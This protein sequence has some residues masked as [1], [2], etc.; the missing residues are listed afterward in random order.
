MK[1]VLK[2]AFV[3][4]LCSLSANAQTY[5]FDHLTN[6]KSTFDG[7]ASNT[8]A[9]HNSNDDSFI[10]FVY[11]DSENEI[12]AHLTDNRNHK[13]HK[14]KVAGNDADSTILLKFT[15]LSSRPYNRDPSRFADYGYRFVKTDSSDSDNVRFRVEIFANK[16]KKKPITHF[17]L[18]A[19]KSYENNFHFFR[20]VI[21]PFEFESRFNIDGY[22]ITQ[23]NW[24]NFTNRVQN[25][26]LTELK[27]TDLVL[28]VP[29]K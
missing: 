10:L 26:Q 22:V 29:L 7:R 8:I 21:H 5:Q 9:Y 28:E 1:T 15:Y 16:K 18:K 11:K 3:L 4:I 6:Y 14:F 20:N 24:I 2:F 27:E 17:D 12:Y 25:Y 23:A 19:R 13:S